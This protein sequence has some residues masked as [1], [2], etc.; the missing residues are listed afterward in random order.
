MDCWNQRT[1]TKVIDRLL[2]SSL[3]LIDDE[4]NGK[5]LDPQ[6]VIDE[7]KK[8]INLCASEVEKLEIFRKKFESTYIKNASK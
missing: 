6:L 2:E 5:T 7:H 4:R 8:C 1:F 3:I